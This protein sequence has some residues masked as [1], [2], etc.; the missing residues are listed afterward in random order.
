M[1]SD[2]PAS[3]PD[4]AAPAVPSSLVAG[5]PPQQLPHVG[6]IFHLMCGH[7]EYGL[8]LLHVSLHLLLLCLAEQVQSRG[9]H[10]IRRR[11]TALCL[12]LPGPTLGSNVAQLACHNETPASYCG[13]SKTCEYSISS[14]LIKLI[15][16]SCLR[17]L[18]A[19]PPARLRPADAA[20]WT[21]PGKFA[22]NAPRVRPRPH[23]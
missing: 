22:G 7:I 14:C 23:S 13:E 4:V 6:A 17:N 20:P 15:P 9:D 3:A 19:P 2:Q 1:V 18:A 5:G 11:L 12:H 10:C 16:Y 21:A 8:H